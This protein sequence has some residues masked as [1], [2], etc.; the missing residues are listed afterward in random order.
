MSEWQ[1]IR[2]LTLAATTRPSRSMLRGKGPIANELC[3][4]SS[5]RHLTERRFRIPLCL[6]VRRTS[7]DFHRPSGRFI[8][9]V[10]LLLAVMV[11]GLATL[12]TS[13]I[14]HAW[15]HPDCHDRNHVCAVTLYAQGTTVPLTVVSVPSIVWRQADVAALRGETCVRPAPSYLLPPGRGPPRLG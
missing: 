3:H 6:S 5:R 1:L 9:A 7:A 12:A 14:A 13:P 2:S 4:P 11:L 15:L 8:Q 10:A